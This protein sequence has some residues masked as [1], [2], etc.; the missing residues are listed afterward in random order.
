[1]GRRFA[2]LA[3]ALTLGLVALAPV[4]AQTPARV[5]TIGVLIPGPAT[6]A[7]RNAVTRGL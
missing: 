2:L 5:P 3:L 1:M 7:G 6:I 4:L